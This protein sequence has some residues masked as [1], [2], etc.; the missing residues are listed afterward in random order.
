MITRFDFLVKYKLTYHITG[1]QGS[2]VIATCVH[3]FV[4][5]I[6]FKLVLAHSLVKSAFD[7]GFERQW[8]VVNCR[9]PGRYILL[10]V[11]MQPAGRG[12]Q[13][14]EVAA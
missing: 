1:V 14:P 3:K 10:T 11:P 9:W 7:L 5:R 2:T 8:S 6:C 4:S 12:M 13:A